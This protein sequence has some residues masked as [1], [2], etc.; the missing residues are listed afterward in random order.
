M[1]FDLSLFSLKLKK[2]REQFKTPLIQMSLET[3]IPE[4]S[5]RQL[6]H[7]ERR[8]TGDEVLILADYYKCDYQFFIS[9]EKLA[10]FEQTETLFRRYGEE[11]SREDR[12]AV[13]EFLLLCE[14]E[15]F[16]ISLFPTDNYNQFSFTK[17]GNYFKKHGEEAATKLRQHLGYSY[18]QV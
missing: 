18:N 8:P 13:Q 5:L 14:C 6:E 4:E 16:L 10:T 17:K 7:A 11:F 1:T 9:N 2:Y 15:H 3:G 12:W